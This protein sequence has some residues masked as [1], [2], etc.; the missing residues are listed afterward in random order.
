MKIPRE[1]HVERML[2]CRVCDRDDVPL[3]RL[4][5][6][7]AEWLDGEL[8]VTEFH[9]GPAALLERVGGFLLQLPLVGWLPIKRWQY[10][11]PW[12]LMDFSD[13][14]RPRVR[15]CRAELGDHFSFL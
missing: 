4:Q 2:G 9:L 8:V 7:R 11:I 15:A 12:E 10:R 5:E 3:G 6:C 1:V 14:R 13:P